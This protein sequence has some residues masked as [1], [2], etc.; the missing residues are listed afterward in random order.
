V[1]NWLKSAGIAIASV[2]AA[3]ACPPVVGE[4]LWMMTACELSA[5]YPSE[6]DATIARVRETLGNAPNDVQA[7]FVVGQAAG[8]VPFNQKGHPDQLLQIPIAFVSAGEIQGT[9]QK[10]DFI[11]DVDAYN[12]FTEIARDKETVDLRAFLLLLS[13]LAT[14]RGT[15]LLVLKN[16][17]NYAVA[18][19][20]LPEDFCRWADVRL[21]EFDI[22]GSVDAVDASGNVGPV[23]WS[24]SPRECMEATS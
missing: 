7:L 19:A 16:Y 2:S 10:R 11:A 18:I 15:R 21:D 13:E 24:T 4:A 12:E 23:D 5:G 6:L 20:V 14:K 3:N 1:L 9:M 8:G 17:L 22:L